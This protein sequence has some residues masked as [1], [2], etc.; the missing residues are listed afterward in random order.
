MGWMPTDPQTRA[1][2]DLPNYAADTDRERQIQLKQQGMTSQEMQGIR[3][4]DIKAG[5]AKTQAEAGTEQARI[6]AAAAVEAA[7]LRYG[8]YAKGGPVFKYKTDHPFNES[9]SSKLLKKSRG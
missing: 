4:G 3:E 7:R 9:F 6:Q 5:I 8:R 2:M 1:A